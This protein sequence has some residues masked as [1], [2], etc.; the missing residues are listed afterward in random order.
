MPVGRWV[1]EE[2][3]RQGAAWQRQG[4]RVTVSINVSAK[5]LDRDQ[6]VADV[7]DALTTAASILPC[8]SWN[9]PRPP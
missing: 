3:C 8:A 2:A 9:S 1:L 5:Q 6:I 4:H 7:H